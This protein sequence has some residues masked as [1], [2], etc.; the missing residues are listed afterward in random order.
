LHPE[1]KSA[2]LTFLKNLNE[3]VKTKLKKLTEGTGEFLSPEDEDIVIDRLTSLQSKLAAAEIAIRE[4]AN[5]P[6]SESL[7][8]FSIALTG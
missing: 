5:S 6:I 3:N 2:L 8:Q 7:K 4:K 1:V